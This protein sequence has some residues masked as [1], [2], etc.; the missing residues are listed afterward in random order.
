MLWLQAHLQEIDNHGVGQAGAAQ[1]SLPP[2]TMMRVKELMVAV[3]PKLPFPQE[4]GRS[5]S[6]RA[7]LGIKVAHCCQ[8]PS[9]YKEV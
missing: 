4:V 3:Y 2:P 6:E 7:C 8:G 5:P 9:L 1:L